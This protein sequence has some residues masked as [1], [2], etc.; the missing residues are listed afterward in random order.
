MTT[1]FRLGWLLAG[2][3]LFCVLSSGCGMSDVDPQAQIWQEFPVAFENAQAVTD[4]PWNFNAGIIDSNGSFIFLTPNTAARIWIE[5]EKKPSFACEIH[6]WVAEISDGVS[7]CVSYL[8]RKGTVLYEENIVLNNTESYHFSVDVYSYPR[9]RSVVVQCGCGEHDNY[10]AD[11][12][13]IRRTYP[14]P[15]TFTQRGYVKSATYYGDE[16]PI[17]FWNSEMDHL[18][19]DMRQIKD[20]GFDS[21][22]ICI[23]WR[24]FQT[25]TDPVT[26]S[27]YAFDQLDRVMNAAQEAGLGVY[28]RISYTWDFWN[29]TEEYLFDRFYH[30]LSEP[31]ERDAWMDYA[32]TLYKHLRKYDSFCGAFL[33]WEDFWEILNVCGIEDRTVRLAY[34]R[35]MGYQ[36]WVREHYSLQDYNLRYAVSYTDYNA[37]PIPLRLE[38]AMESMYDFFDEFLNSFLR[39]AQEVFP[40]LSNEVRLDGDR[41]FD[42]NQEAQY[43]YH[44]VTYTCENADYTAVMYAIPMGFSNEGEQVGARKAVQHTQYAFVSLLSQNKGKPV[45]AEQFLFYDNTPEFSH[46]AHLIEDE[47]EEYL[48]LV[49]DVLLQYTAGYGV[50]TYRDYCYNMLY[51]NGFYLKDLGWECI[52]RVSFQ[53][54]DGSMTAHLEAGNGLSQHIKEIRN[55]PGIDAYE[56]SLEVRRCDAPGTLLV[57][58]GEY[59]DSINITGPGRYS[60]SVPKTASFDLSVSAESGAFDLD[61]L[62][63]YNFV[64]EGYLYSQDNQEQRFIESIRRLNMALSAE[65]NR[66]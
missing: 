66:G 12:L 54:T 61:N 4:N 57:R 36:Q 29:D 55:L 8:D 11:W 27:D 33:T 9:C 59:E 31:N 3:L 1:R 65:G 51:N 39:R 21:I 63:L 15:S 53:E 46:N 7:I 19:A 28:A 48:D 42:S 13:L 35:S 44:Q 47:V 38:P 32:K 34:A 24:E 18:D 23:P 62:R 2:L 30:L 5:E 49:A 45:Y 20:D 17:N 14:Q 25:D 60:L 37:I 40:N 64:Q 58:V 6:P 10:D 56:F 22:I 50:W 26:Y 43:H 41:V 16:W 52:G